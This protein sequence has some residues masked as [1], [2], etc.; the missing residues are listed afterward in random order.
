MRSAGHLPQLDERQR[1]AEVAQRPAPRHLGLIQDG[2]QRYARQAGRSN[3]EGYRRGAGTPRDVLTWCA[4]LKIPM[5]SLWWLSTE[6]LAREPR[7]VAAVLSVI[8]E[9]VAEWVPAG[10]AQRLGIRIRPM[11]KL[12]LL[13]APTLQVLQQAE[14]ATRDHDRILLNVGVGYG[15][16]Q[17]ILDA[18]TGIWLTASA[19]GPRRKRFCRA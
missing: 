15:G 7:E 5:V 1:L 6:N 19:V 18:V 10:L 14:T 16:R 12:D 4:E 8:E 3:L 13:P 11:G 2:H 9:K 17:E